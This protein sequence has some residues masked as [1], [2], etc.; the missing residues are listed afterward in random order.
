MV[1]QPGASE[2]YRGRFSVDGDR[3]GVWEEGDDLFYANFCAVGGL[4]GKAVGGLVGKDICALRGMR[5]ASQNGVFLM[6]A[7]DH[8]GSGP[9]KEIWRF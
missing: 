8:F 3:T 5:D 6:H 4:V 2:E 1:A 7:N 9:Q